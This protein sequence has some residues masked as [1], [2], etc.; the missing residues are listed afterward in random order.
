M[1]ITVN[2]NIYQNLFTSQTIRKHE[3][4]IEYADHISQW[5]E[6]NAKEYA[7]FRSRAFMHK[8]NVR[9]LWRNETDELLSR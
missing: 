3:F 1:S 9:F 8:S 4:K 6:N 5:N 7:K 2:T